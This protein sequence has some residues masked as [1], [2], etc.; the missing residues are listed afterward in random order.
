MIGLRLQLEFLNESFQ[1][2]FGRLGLAEHD[3]DWL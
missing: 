2:L 1:G 3:K